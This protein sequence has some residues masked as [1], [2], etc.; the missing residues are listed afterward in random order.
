MTHEQPVSTRIVPGG[1]VTAVG[2]VIDA[3]T[4]LIAEHG[5]LYQWASTVPQPTALR[6]R[7]PVY[8]ATVPRTTDTVVV[9]HAWHGGLFAPLTGDRFRMP[10]RAPTELARSNALRREGIPTSEVLGFARYSAGLGLRTVDVVSRFIPDAADLGMIAADLVPGLALSAAL[11][12]TV[13]LLNTMAT[14]GVI[15]PDLNV[16]NILVRR[17]A[18]RAPEALIID[19]DVVRWE[20]ER[21]P[22]ETMAVNVRRL[23]R[24]MQKWR[25]QFGCN[26]SDTQLAAFVVRATDTV[27][28]VTPISRVDR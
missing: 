24:S 21:A 20:K 27:A 13:T 26:L 5:S 10:T 25:T 17:G 28:R 8:V 18:G 22:A 1:D 4:A 19:V 12:A 2:S 6:G 9:R 7:A 11:D 3:F 23:V 14:H 16:K 15:H